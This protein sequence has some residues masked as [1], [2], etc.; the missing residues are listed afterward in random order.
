MPQIVLTTGANKEQ[1]ADLAL[2]AAVSCLAPPRMSPCTL[3]RRPPHAACRAS[4]RAHA[5]RSPRMQ[6]L[7]S[8]GLEFC[9][10]TVVKQRC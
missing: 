3:A 5:P 8:C 10:D 1:L 9:R 7:R 6:A 4:P 2:I